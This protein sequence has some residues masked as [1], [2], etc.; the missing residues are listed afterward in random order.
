MLQL[1]PTKTSDI[2]VII[3]GAGLSGLSAARKLQMAGKNVLVLEAQNKV[4]GRVCEQTSDLCGI[5]LNFGAHSLSPSQYKMCDLLDELG[6]KVQ[7]QYNEGKNILAINGKQG[8]YTKV[9]PNLWPHQ[10]GNLQWNLKKLKQLHESVLLKNIDKTAN[11]LNLDAQTVAEWCDDKLWFKDSKRLFE[12]W[13]KQLFAA[14]IN[15]LS[16]LH[17]LGYLQ[18]GGGFKHLL[19]SKEGANSLLVEGGMQQVVNGIALG[20]NQA[21]KCNSAV[22]AIHSSNEGV[23]V[24]TKNATYKSRYAIVAIPPKLAAKIYYKPTLSNKRQQ[25]LQNMPNGTVITCAVFYEKPFWRDKNLSGQILTDTKPLTVVFDASP[26]NNRA[27]VLMGY[28]VGDNAKYLSHYTQQER[29]EKVI[30][31]LVGVLGDEAKKM[32]DYKEMNWGEKEWIEGGFAT[33]VPVNVWTKYGEALRE[34]EGNVHWAGT[35]TAIV[36]NGYMDGALE[37]GWRAA[38]EVLKRFMEEV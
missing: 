13:I 15:D 12:L 14:E 4:G 10:L 38:A 29:Q 7:K 37:A 11:A 35:E 31:Q 1:T 33:A 3:V 22:V 6:L 18:S 24:N 27:G 34:P 16:L 21:V 36:W 2:D 30:E 28:V 23:E 20:L 26:N 17:F 25:L 32:K 5:T 9:F 8:K 19:D